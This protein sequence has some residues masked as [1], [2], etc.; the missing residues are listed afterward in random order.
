MEPS[1]FG[2]SYEQGDNQES[3][4]SYFT[5]RDGCKIYFRTHGIDTS[6]PVVIFLNGTTQTTFY[7]GGHVPAFSKQF[8]LLFYDARA[9]GQSALG[10]KPLTLERHVSDLKEL[11][12][13]LGIDT[14]HL[15]GLSHGAR[16]ALALASDSPKM[17]N[18]LVLCSLGARTN[19]RSRIAVQSWLKILQL[20][21]LEA[22]AWAALP[23]V[24]GS[25]F[26]RHRHKTMAMIVGAVAKRNNK[27]ALMAQ[28]DAILQYPSPGRMPAV[29][30][31]PILVL[32]GT[33]DAL[34]S[35]KDAGE[36]ANLCNAR[37]AE[38]TGIGHSIPAEAPRVFEKLVLEFLT[39]KP[40]KPELTI[41]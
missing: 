22:M 33:E 7:W 19:Y 18:R 41:E 32:S 38:L 23:T 21:G 30:E 4:M 13:H 12:A 26:L 5:T 28:L 36:L 8:R 25:N 9:Q 14:A 24:F 35:P 15:V 39:N 27:K 3:T 10:D 31:G 20:S 1:I 34:V 2:V 40:V 11:C 16:L 6:Y 29:F 37:H 17:V